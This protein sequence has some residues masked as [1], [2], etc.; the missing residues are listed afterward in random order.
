MWLVH[1]LGPHEMAS[2]WSSEKLSEFLLLAEVW[3]DK[4]LCQCVQWSEKGHKTFLLVYPRMLGSLWQW[5][6]GEDAVSTIP[7]PQDDNS[8][9]NVSCLLGS[10]LKLVPSIA[11]FELAEIL[12][13]GSHHGINNIKVRGSGDVC[14]KIEWLSAKCDLIRCG[15][16]CWIPRRIMGVLCPCKKLAPSR[17][18]VVNKGLQILFNYTV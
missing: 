9:H 14:Q 10:S 18:P 16:C 11:S 15:A 4:P 8:H 17:W 7:T 12:H 1:L 6:A 5:I 13:R 2:A 3:D